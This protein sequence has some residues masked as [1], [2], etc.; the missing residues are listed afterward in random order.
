M[1]PLPLYVLRE[2]L[3]YLASILSRIVNAFVRDDEGNWGSMHQ[4]FS[5][6]CHMLA[7]RSERFDRYRKRI[8]AVFFWQEDHCHKAWDEQLTRA[9]KTV[10]YNS[11]IDGQI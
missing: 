10:A 4:T 3:W 9:R 11:T 8:N 1:L 6:R 2:S 7:P 5:A